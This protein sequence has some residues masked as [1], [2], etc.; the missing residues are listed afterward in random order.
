LA[1]ALGFMALTGQLAEPVKAKLNESVVFGEI[2][3]EGQ[4]YAPPD[5][6]SALRAAGLP[7]VTGLAAG[8]IREG[9]WLELQR[10]NA[11][12]LNSISRHFDWQEFWQRPRF[13]NIQFHVQ[14]SEALCL[15]VHM[16]LNVLLAG[17]QGSGKSTWARALH[18]LTPPP[19]P[20]LMSELE[21]MFGEDAIRS[22]WRPWESPHHTITP[23]AMIGGGNPI[24][25]GII[26][27]AHG[28]VLVMDEFL[29]FDGQV[30]E[31]LREPI[32]NGHIEHARHGNRVRFPAKFQLIGTTNLCPCGKMEP[33]KRVECCTP[34]MRCRSVSDRLSGPLLDRFDVLLYSH[35][36][37][38]KNARFSWNQIQD[39]I[40]AASEFRKL[41]GEELLAVPEWVQDLELGYR[42]RSALL[43]VARGL[44]D[45][46]QSRLVDHMDFKEAYLYVV[47]PME[48]VRQLFG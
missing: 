26:S 8:H 44:A 2:S 28:G 47:E 6:P 3:L 25:P 45:L 39:R 35:R 24:E 14:A 38:A 22:R 21:D 48:A 9:S 23:L 4:V 29:E 43:R 40:A 33:G 42:R 7:V 17:P 41:R 30:L 11:G 10:L 34:R 15:A 46:R 36:W 19:N 12:Q 1:I 27:R 31:A 20:T 18:S 32:E 37:H 16:S 5:L 13:E